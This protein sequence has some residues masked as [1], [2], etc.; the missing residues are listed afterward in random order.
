M[1]SQVS[2]SFLR[3]C[4]LRRFRRLKIHSLFKMTDG[5]YRIYTYMRSL[6]LLIKLLDDKNTLFTIVLATLQAT[7]NLLIFINFFLTFDI[8]ALNLLFSIL[9]NQ[10]LKRVIFLTILPFLLPFFF[11]TFLSILIFT[12]TLT[13]QNH[14][15]IFWAL[16]AANDF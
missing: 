4:F 9:L 11:L 13:Y 1:K 14:F 12:L 5:S 8:R 15:L 7:Q 16:L 10:H 3:G 2:F 6:R